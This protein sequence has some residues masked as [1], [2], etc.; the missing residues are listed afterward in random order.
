MDTNW[1]LEV[2]MDADKEEPDVKQG[3][4]AVFDLIAQRRLDDAQAKI[5]E[6]RQQIGNS[7]TLQ[8]AASTIDRIRMLNR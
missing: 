4:E 1:I 5:V 2:L 7:E 8:R 3:I 6:I